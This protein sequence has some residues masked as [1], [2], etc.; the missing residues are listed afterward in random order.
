MSLKQLIPIVS[1]MSCE[2][3]HMTYV[4]LIHYFGLVTFML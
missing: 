4:L 3:E 1:E 2:N